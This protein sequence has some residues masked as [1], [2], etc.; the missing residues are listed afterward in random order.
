MK[1][2]TAEKRIMAHLEKIMKI[3][4]EYYPDNAYLDL[5]IVGNFCRFN[6]AYWEHEGVGKLQCFK[7][8]I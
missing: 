5:S 1:R 2:T 6:N 4:K 8:V 3:A 7:E